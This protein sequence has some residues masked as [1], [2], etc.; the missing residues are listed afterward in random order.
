MQRPLMGE[1]RIFFLQLI[2]GIE[3]PGDSKLINNAEGLF[4][5]VKVEYGKK[6]SLGQFYLVANVDYSNGQEI[7]DPG[8]YFL[9]RIDDENYYLVVMQNDNNGGGRRLATLDDSYFAEKW[10]MTIKEQQGL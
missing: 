10:L 3:K 1:A 7:Y 5:Q 4:Y 6:V 2:E 8:M 9:D